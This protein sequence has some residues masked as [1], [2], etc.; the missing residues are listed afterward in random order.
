MYSQPKKFLDRGVL[1]V[2]QAAWIACL[3]NIFACYDVNAASYKGVGGQIEAYG[4]VLIA[5]LHPQHIIAVCGN[6]YPILENEAIT[7]DRFFISKNKPI[8]EQVTEMIKAHAYKNGGFKELGRL[9]KE[10]T[11]SLPLMVKI[12]DSAPQEITAT[13]NSCRKV[14]NL[15]LEG[16]M[17]LDITSQ[18]W[19]NRIL[20][21]N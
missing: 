20:Y 10:I 14:I 13:E 1:S 6:R 15:I 21:G 9:S 8:Y 5:Y 18:K 7:A 16:N 4:S 12:F 2:R 19:I 17:N 11:D 3:F